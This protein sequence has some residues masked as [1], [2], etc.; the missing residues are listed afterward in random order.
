MRFVDEIEFVVRSGNGGKGAISFRREKHVPR[1]GPDG[2]DGGR[3]GSVILEATR[4]RNTLVDFR[5]NKVYSAQSGEPGK[6]NRA[7]GRSGKDLLLEVPVGTVVWNATTGEQLADLSEAGEQ[8]TI[9]GGHGG[10]GN[11]HFKSSTRRTPRFAT[12]GGEGI[13][14]RL[15]LELKL[16]AD[17]GLLGF[18]NAGKSTF[19]STISAARP[20]VA[21]YPFTTLVP[22]L[23][24]VRVGTGN[25]FVVADIPGLIEGAAEGIGLG[26]Q[27]LRHVERCS[28]YVH[29]V[30]ASDPLGSPVERYTA[31][32]RELAQYDDSLPKRPQLVALSKVDTLPDDEVA[33]LCAELQSVCGTPV[34]PISSVSRKGL[35]PLLHAVWSVVQAD[36]ER[37]APA[38][39][40]EE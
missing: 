23:G 30:A 11:V 34:F 31:L 3:G 21:E 14:L 39:G 8:W 25:S 4:Q 26:H 12:P 9:E 33:T 19:V 35:G 15:R 5:M 7:Y 6:G 40:E 28:L 37:R 24:V 22:S 27:F 10:K 2:G 20:K 1:G 38:E 29:L 17:V 36:R 32:Q 18:P 16:I 13:E